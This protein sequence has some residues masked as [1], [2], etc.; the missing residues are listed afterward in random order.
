MKQINL[1]ENIALILYKGG[2]LNI[3]SSHL[4]KK[5]KSRKSFNKKW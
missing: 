2:M 1:I 5:I 4:V 3:F